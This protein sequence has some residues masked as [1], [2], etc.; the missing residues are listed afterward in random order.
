M[1]PDE[2]KRMIEAGIEGAAA[3]VSGDGSHFDAIV[4]SEKFAGLNT[5]KKQQMVF[6]VLGDKVT[7]GEI[8]ALN[9]KAYTPEEWRKTRG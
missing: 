5:L 4:I 6:G 2:I 9:I 3:E 1:Q 8:H 7:G